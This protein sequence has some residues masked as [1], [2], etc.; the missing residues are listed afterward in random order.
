MIAFVPSLS[1]HN[2]L[3][4]Q[5]ETF[6]PIDSVGRMVSF[7]SCGP[8]VYDDAHVGNFARFSMPT[9]CAAL[10]NSLDIASVT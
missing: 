4:R 7:Y 9:F 5:T 6:T 10:W 2:T 3:T 8:T 1:L